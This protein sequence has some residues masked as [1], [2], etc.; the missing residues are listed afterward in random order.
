[1]AG[2]TKKELWMNLEQGQIGKRTNKLGRRIVVKF[3]K[4][5]RRRRR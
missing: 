1:M 5:A 2:N 3:K 4:P